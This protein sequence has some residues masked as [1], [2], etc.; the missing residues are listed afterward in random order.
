MKNKS[1]GKKTQEKKVW[2]PKETI[3]CLLAHDFPRASSK[4]NWYFD[5]G[6]SQYMIGERGYIE[7]LKSHSNNYVTLGDGARRKIK[8]IGKLVCPCLPSL[9]NVLLVEGLTE[10]LISISQPCYQ[11]LI[12]SFNKVDCIVSSKDQEELMKGSR[13]L[14]NCYIWVPQAP[15]CMISKVY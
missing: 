5:S 11:G 7:G 3:K 8:G 13:S 12:M 2:K 6:C 9:N 10:N 1:K 4:G 15:P 14:G